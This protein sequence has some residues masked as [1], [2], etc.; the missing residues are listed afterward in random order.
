MDQFVQWQIG[1]EVVI[2]VCFIVESRSEVMRGAVEIRCM[3]TR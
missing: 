1:G 3:T 2:I